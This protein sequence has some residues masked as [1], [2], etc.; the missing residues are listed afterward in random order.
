MATQER[1][2]LVGTDPMIETLAIIAKF[3]ALADTAYIRTL[4]DSATLGDVRRGDPAA[5]GDV[6]EVFD[7]SR[8][9][10]TDLKCRELPDSTPYSAED[11][12]GS[13]WWY[14]RFPLARLRTEECVPR[15]LL[16]EF[17]QPDTAYGM[18]YE[19]ATWFRREDSEAIIRRL[20]ELGYK[21]EAGPE[22][23]RILDDYRYGG[24]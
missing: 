20:L 4:D 16:G 21:A 7:A 10:T 17:G 22:S 15:E 2:L 14:M 1:V 19:Q 18:D 3:Q 8:E 11:W 12:F 24:V 5:L 9:D 23:Q 6:E 13:D